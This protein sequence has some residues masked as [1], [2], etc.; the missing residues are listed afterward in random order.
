MFNLSKLGQQLYSGERSLNVIGKRKAFLSVSLAVILIASLAVGIFRLNPGIEFRGGSEFTISQVQTNKQDIAY[1]ALKKADIKDGARV[2]NVGL[3]GI[4]VQ[5]Q[6]LTPAQTTKVAKILADAYKVKAENVTST[7][8]GPSWGAGVTKKALTS[9]II[10]IVFVSLMMTLYFHNW[11]M[12]AAALFALVND[13][14]VLAG[15]FALTQIEVSPATVIGFL[16]ILAYSLYDTVVVFDKVRELT[17]GY[18]GQYRYTYGELVNLAVN[19]TFVRSINTSVVAL[20]PV[21]SILVIGAMLLGAGT[22]LDISLAL[23]VGMISGAFS[24]L[25][26]A[27]PLLTWL[28]D[29]TESAKK[30]NSAVLSRREGTTVESESVDGET[31]L[32]PVR[33]APLSAGGH[34]GQAA[35]PKRKKRSKR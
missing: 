31:K 5:T 18:Q 26:I 23:F 7:F 27:S 35:Q 17:K 21:A 15:F 24:S 10:F 22:L 13:M 9:L 25:F 8:V 14:F 3:D 34:L 4:R 30:H 29:R 32:A 33:V 12:A 6:S 1:E 20:L 11:R 16:T 2:S 28:N 19:Q